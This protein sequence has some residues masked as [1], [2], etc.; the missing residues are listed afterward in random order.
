MSSA[1]ESVS[2]ETYYELRLIIEEQRHQMIQE[3]K[4]ARAQ[5]PKCPLCRKD[6][7][8]L[9][10]KA[11]D[12]ITKE[13]GPGENGLRVCY[14]RRKSAPVAAPAAVPVATQATAP[15]VDSVSD[16]KGEGNDFSASMALE[17]GSW[18][19]LGHR[20]AEPRARAPHRPIRS[21]RDR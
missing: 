9:D 10:L 17:L 15:T 20:L 14:K 4:R 16:V 5:V 18:E 12:K 1:F 6:I 19:T 2:V 11:W 7:K 8:A 3:H 21:T 13:E